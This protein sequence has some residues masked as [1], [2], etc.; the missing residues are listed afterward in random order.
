MVL[1]RSA[2]VINPRFPVAEMA[3]VA[4]LFANPDII[5]TDPANELQKL[6]IIKRQAVNL[7]RT[8]LK[9]IKD[10]IIK[11]DKVMQQ[12][13]SNNFEIRRLLQLMES[14][15]TNIGQASVDSPT[16]KGIQGIIRNQ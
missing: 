4:E 13:Q 11:D 15:P 6:V 2:L 14:I 12:V 1:G 16:V 5:F 10:G 7:L 8:N 9:A 3:N